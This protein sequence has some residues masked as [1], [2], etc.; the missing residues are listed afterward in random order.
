MLCT[1]FDTVH[2][3]P[4]ASG[5][6]FSGPSFRYAL[7]QNHLSPLQAG[8]AGRAEM[9]AGASNAGASESTGVR[10]EGRGG[11]RPHAH[12]PGRLHEQAAGRPQAGRAGCLTECN[13]AL[14]H[15]NTL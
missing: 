10:A 5:P 13:L 4:A 2:S 6:S 15:T 14:I 9:E 7:L 11:G 12:L 1:A 3:R 8:R